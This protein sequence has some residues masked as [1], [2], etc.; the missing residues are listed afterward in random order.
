MA[1]GRKGRVGGGRPSATRSWRVDAVAEGHEQIRN[2]KSE[3]LNSSFLIPH[4][5]F[6]QLWL[7]PRSSMEPAKAVGRSGLKV[8]IITAS[9]SVRVVPM[10]AS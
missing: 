7:Y 6:T 10:E 5:Y 1:D 9:S 2:P 4:S 8:S 3:F